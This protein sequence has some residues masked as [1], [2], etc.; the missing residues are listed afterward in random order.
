MYSVSSFCPILYAVACCAIGIWTVYEIYTHWNTVYS[1]TVTR[2]AWNT[3]E[4]AHFRELVTTSQ[5]DTWNKFVTA[6]SLHYHYENTAW[7]KHEEYELTDYKSFTWITSFRPTREGLWFAEY[8]SAHQKW[9]LKI[10]SK[11]GQNWKREYEYEGPVWFTLRIFVR[12]VVHGPI[13][14]IMVAADMLL[15]ETISSSLIM[16]GSLVCQMLESFGIGFLKMFLASVRFLIILLVQV[17]N[18]L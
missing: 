16:I 9:T 5:L 4:Y 13:G 8:K 6:L 2:Y 18:D 12:I 7:Q 17:I 11:R 10:H 14:M 3:E 1:A 15:P